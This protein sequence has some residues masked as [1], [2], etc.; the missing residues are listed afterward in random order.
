[1]PAENS[2]I[3]HSGIP[4]RAKDPKTCPFHSAELRMNDA[5][6]F[7]DLDGYFRFRAQWEDAKNTTAEVREFIN[8]QPT[9]KPVETFAITDANQLN[10]LLEY[11]GDELVT[12]TDGSTAKLTY[13]DD[14]PTRHPKFNQL[15]VRREDG[16]LFAISH[17]ND[18]ASTKEWNGAQ[19]LSLTRVEAEDTL[20]IVTNYRPAHKASFDDVEESA[21]A[22]A[23]HTQ[24]LLNDA[25]ESLEF[26][27]QEF[28]DGQGYTIAGVNAPGNR[29][30]LTKAQE[31]TRNSLNRILANTVQDED[32]ISV[33]KNV[34]YVE[35][36][37][38]DYQE[39]LNP[40]S[41]EYRSVGQARRILRQNTTWD[42]NGGEADAP[43]VLRAMDSKFLTQDKA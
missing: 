19:G 26:R 32:G 42:N 10:N 4:C 9:G 11:G 25:D 16:A 36:L 7:N 30:D 22:Q 43:A 35:S 40:T 18:A 8:A 21:D 31:G 29:I 6:R 41:P 28:H 34:E 33:V 12:L 5:V 24:E 2:L 17:R 37:L 20:R 38:E 13:V 39:G 15:V 23:A 3:T 27:L 14:V 1:M